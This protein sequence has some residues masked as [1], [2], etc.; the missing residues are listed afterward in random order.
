MILDLLRELG[1]HTVE[2]LL[3]PRQYGIPNSRLRY[4]LVARRSPFVD[5]TQTNTV[6]DHI[7]STRDNEI[8]ST[9]MRRISWYLDEAMDESTVVPDR[10][11]EKW[12]KLFD[13]VMPSGDTS[14]C[15]TRG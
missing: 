9:I 6:W 14:C 5:V 15:F 7:P 10:I 1:Y 8:P 4:Y 13:I 11:L 2:F 3:T 12:G